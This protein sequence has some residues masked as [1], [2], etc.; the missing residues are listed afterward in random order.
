MSRTGYAVGLLCVAS[1]CGASCTARAPHPYAGV[2]HSPAAA[3]HQPVT[4]L[5]GFYGNSTF[6]SVARTLLLSGTQ[7]SPLPASWATGIPVLGYGSSH[8]PL[9]VDQ[10]N[11][12]LDYDPTY[13]LESSTLAFY[14]GHGKG[15][16]GWYVPPR[17]AVVPITQ[18]HV[19]DLSLRYFWLY[20]CKV[21]AHGPRMVVGGRNYSAPQYF[22][23]GDADVFARWTPAFAS[24]MRMVCGGSTDLGHITKVGEIWSYLLEDETSVADAW[25][26]GLANPKEVP[27]CL[28]RGGEK[29][30]FSALSDRTLHT[31]GVA[32]GGWLHFQYPVNCTVERENISPLHVVCNRQPAPTGG[33]TS[34]SGA[35]SEPPPVLREPPLPTEALTVTTTRRQAPAPIDV[36]RPLGFVGLVGPVNRKYHSDSGAVVLIKD[37]QH[38]DLYNRLGS[39]DEET[40]WTIQPSALLKEAGRGLEL[41]SS[42]AAEQ[43]AGQLLKDFSF[44]ALE[45]R[46]ESRQDGH[47]DRIC[48]ARSLFLLL[49]KK[50]DVAPESYPVFGPAV[51]LE[52]QRQGDQEAKLASFSAPRGKPTVDKGVQPI[53]LKPAPDAINQAHEALQLNAEEYPIANARVTF[54]YEEA[55]LR[56]QQEFLRPTYE[57]RFFPAEAV[58][59]NRPTVTV[60][61]DARLNP[62]ETSW[63]CRGWG[64]FPAPQ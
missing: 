15:I 2:P 30:A 19:G 64:A 31:E 44:T 4:S 40:T 18:V 39:C 56:C 59:D 36:G 53:P 55:P 24:N 9:Y 12:G 37:R 51:V 41:F 23:P 7:P 5:H 20:S 47:S 28:A 54:G 17:N 11:H 42:D 22:Q 10:H 63:T 6:V 45:M 49:H 58:Q 57:I 32:Q 60:R 35:P 21:M 13:G 43:D 61:R 3:P 8:Q 62:P 29:P 46:V 16:D 33:K 14:A 34:P 1:L 25:I 50:V 27:V 52:L 38:R 48:T 26:L